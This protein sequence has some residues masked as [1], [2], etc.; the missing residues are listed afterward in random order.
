M[1]KLTVA[2]LI[3]LLEWCDPNSLVCTRSDGDYREA[4]AVAIVDET[5]IAISSLVPQACVSLREI[6]FDIRTLQEV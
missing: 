2:D 3:R 1:K 6:G 5:R 4:N